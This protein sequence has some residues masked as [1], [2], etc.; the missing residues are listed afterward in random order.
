MSPKIEYLPPAARG[1]LA[2]AAATFRHVLLIDGVFHHD[3]AV[4]PKEAYEAAQ[5]CRLSGAAS[6]GALRAAECA[7]Y[8][9][10]PV[11]VI[12]AWFRYGVIDGDDEVAVAVDPRT[13]SAW[14]VPLVNVRFLM[15]RAVAG[16][17]LSRWESEIIIEQARRVYYAER[18]WD[19]VLEIAPSHIRTALN[20]LCQNDESDL[21]R[22]DARFSVR[23]LLRSL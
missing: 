11:G 5:R 10:T 1:D 2:Q 6:M 14:T 12:A 9:M 15:R 22:L 21:K 4:S 13:H 20:R 19:D 18:Q 16:R 7:P 23:R 3:L 8:G 17:I